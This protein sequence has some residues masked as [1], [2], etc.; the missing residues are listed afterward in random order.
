MAEKQGEVEARVLT[1]EEQVQ[2]LNLMQKYDELKSKWDR[3]LVR[4][5]Y[6]STTTYLFVAVFMFILEVDN[7]LVNALIPS[8]GYILSTQTL[9]SI[10]KAW[11]RYYLDRELDESQD[12]ESNKN[13]EE[14]KVFEDKP[15]QR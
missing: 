12:E 2:K 8:L 1:L 4:I 9:P 11:V 6:V 3:S 10:K 5:I 14:S 15:Q 13:I 7:Y